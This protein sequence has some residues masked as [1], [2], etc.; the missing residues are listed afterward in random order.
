MVD[1]KIVD[2]VKEQQKEIANLLR[3]FIATPDG[4]CL[5]IPDESSGWSGSDLFVETVI[6]NC[7]PAMFFSKTAAKVLHRREK[8]SK[9]SLLAIHTNDCLSTQ[10][11]LAIFGPLMIIVTL[12]KV[13]FSVSVRM[14]MK[15]FVATIVPSIL[16]MMR[17]TLTFRSAAGGGWPVFVQEGD[18]GEF[19]AQINTGWADDGSVYLLLRDG[20]F[21][22]EAQTG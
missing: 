22:V 16:L 4:A 15:V 6:R 12:Q 10:Y 14:R 18:S 9:K 8:L 11:D 5:A 7:R 13:L 1:S 20:E 3:S 21:I 2:D 19:V 17:S